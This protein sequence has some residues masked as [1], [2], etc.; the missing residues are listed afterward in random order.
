MA[1]AW[2]VSSVAAPSSRPGI[3]DDTQYIEQALRSDPQ[4]R[5]RWLSPKRR[6]IYESVRYRAEVGFT[7]DDVIALGL[8]DESDLDDALRLANEGLTE[9]AAVTVP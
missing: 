8:P 4:R 6:E 9:L 2:A 1:S 3:R 7:E 5:G